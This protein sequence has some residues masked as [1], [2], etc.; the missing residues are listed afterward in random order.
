LGA[1]GYRDKHRAGALRLSRYASGA[2]SRTRR[3]GQQGDEGDAD[4]RA[5]E[6]A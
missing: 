6:R 1:L 3:L 4:G 5:R 2:G